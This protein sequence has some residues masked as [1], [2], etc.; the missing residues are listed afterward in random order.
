MGAHLGRA[1]GGNGF[2]EGLKGPSKCRC[3]E[4]PVAKLAWQVGTQIF[5]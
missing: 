3:E 5:L 1:S 2:I 4:L